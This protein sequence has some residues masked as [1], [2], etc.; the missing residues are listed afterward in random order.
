MGYKELAQNICEQ[1]LHL[2]KISR[3]L[4]V[5][6]DNKVKSVH[7]LVPDKDLQPPKYH[8][9]T[10]IDFLIFLMKIYI[11]EGLALKDDVLQIGDLILKLLKD[12]DDSYAVSKALP[13]VHYLFAKCYQ[14]SGQLELARSHALTAE[15]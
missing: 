1:E 6:P 4:P 9:Q 7:V 5:G 3:N 2:K 12:R 11:S 13:T 10:K 15:A 8:G 14:L